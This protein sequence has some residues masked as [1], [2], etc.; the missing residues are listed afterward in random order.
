M[1]SV[2]VFGLGHVG[3]PVAAA[4]VDAGFNTSGVDISSERVREIRGGSVHWDEPPLN[5][6]GI[7]ESS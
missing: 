4:A 7:A 2:T 6:A 3:L 1:N 5:E